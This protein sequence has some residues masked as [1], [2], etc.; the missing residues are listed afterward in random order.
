MVNENKLNITQGKEQFQHEQDILLKTVLS[1][2]YFLPWRDAF[3]NPSGPSIS[4]VPKGHLEIYI[5][6][7][8]NQKC[9]Y[10]YLVRHPEI[11]PKEFLDKNLILQNLRALYD[12]I[13]ENNFSIPQCEFFT[14]EIWHSN[15]GIE[16]LDITLEYI[17]KG[18]KIQQFLIPSNCSFVRNRAWLDKIQHYI[19]TFAQFGIPLGFSISVDGK[20][21]D[22]EARSG[23]NSSVVYTDEFYD[24]LVEFA[25]YNGFGFHP[26]VAACDI[27]KWIDNYEWWKSIMKKHGLDMGKVMM[28][29]VRNNDWTDEK[30]AHFLEFEKYLINDVLKRHDN[31][32]GDACVDCFGINQTYMDKYGRMMEGAE[33]AA[34]APHHLAE[35]D[36]FLGCT[37]Q[38][39][40][41]VRLG[42]LAIC[43][44]HRTAYN[45]NLFGW[46]KKNTEGRIYDITA[47]NPQAAIRLLLVNNVTATLGCDSCIYNKYCMTPCCGEQ[48]E[49]FNDMFHLD[50]VVC[51][52]LKAKHNFLIKYYKEIGFL[53]WMDENISPYHVFYLHKENLMKLYRDVIEEERC[54]KLEKLR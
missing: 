18:L 29:E 1:E 9:E 4:D 38:N 43:P 26:M 16:I 17:Q 19:N 7:Q 37:I 11:Y 8:C 3:T 10:C 35:I 30:I 42:D 41:T 47:N 28:L 39:N 6:S 2:R 27:E 52:F 22:A 12:W 21:V 46:F 48:M 31:N 24:T 49:E 53:D 33:Q 14:G 54:E 32:I 23:N 15:F 34:Y 45:K 40:L 51:K 44:C 20:I 13:I 5:T 25:K 50:P 36:E